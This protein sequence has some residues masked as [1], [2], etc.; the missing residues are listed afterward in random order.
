MVKFAMALCATLLLLL[1]GNA[2]AGPADG[3]Y[4][5][6][7][8]W[9]V[10]KSPVPSCGPES[11][12]IVSET[13]DAVKDYVLSRDVLLVTGD[14]LPLTI[15]DPQGRLYGVTERRVATDGSKV[16]VYM[17]IKVANDGKT[18]LAAVISVD[19]KVKCADGRIAQFNK[20]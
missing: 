3:T 6:S 5:R 4:V 12:K 20:K 13:A 14:R 7:G 2:S 18:V 16:E 8:S 15:S 10:S 17:G 19:G 9:G 11:S 1:S